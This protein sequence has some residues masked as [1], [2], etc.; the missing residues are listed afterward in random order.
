MSKIEWKK[1]FRP[2]ILERGREYYREDRVEELSDR[3]G[4]ITACVEGSE[5]Y[6]VEIEYSG[7]D[8]EYMYCDCPYAEG[9]EN[10]KHMAA[11]LFA[12]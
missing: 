2:H 9:G 12:W 7:K 8:I 11:V 4:N 10:C 1:Y 3:D 5:P 6:G